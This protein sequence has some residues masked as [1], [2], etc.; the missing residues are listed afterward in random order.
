MTKI[1]ICGITTAADAIMAIELGANAIGLNFSPQSPRCIDLATAKTI[2][3]VTPNTCLLVGVFTNQPEAAVRHIAK[4]VPLEAVQ[5]HGDENPEYCDK[6]IDLTIIKAFRF[7]D[8]VD[9]SLI[10]QYEGIATHYLFDAFSQKARGGTGE[11]IA[12]FILEE[13]AAAGL[14]QKSFLAGG[15]TPENVAQL[16][17]HYRPYGVDVASGVEESPGKKSKAKVEAFISAVK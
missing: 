16:V 1:K 14:L 12:E 2:S 17:K 8:K 10:R 13:L 4:R 3:K 6:F 5:F 15:L 9:L 11:Q 7:S